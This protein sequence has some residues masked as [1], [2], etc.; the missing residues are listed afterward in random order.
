[1]IARLPI[2]VRLTL[3]FA[4][5]MALVLAATGFFIYQRVGSTLIHSIDQSVREQVAEATQHVAHGRDVLDRDTTGGR[6]VGQLIRSDGRVRESTPAGLPAL[7]S[8]AALR[9][10][11][12]GS[13]V[14]RT[15]T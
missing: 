6:A 1:M 14:L 11:R 12:G 3:P 2:R 8:R 13:A 10:V 7:V 9:G 15:L 5:G 4:L